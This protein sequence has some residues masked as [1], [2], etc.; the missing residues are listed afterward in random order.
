M[1]NDLTINRTPEGYFAAYCN[2]CGR[3]VDTIEYETPIQA[4]PNWKR[5]GM[6]EGKHTGEVIITIKCHGETFTVSNWRGEI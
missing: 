1:A 5:F 3:H 4:L 6:L 2:K